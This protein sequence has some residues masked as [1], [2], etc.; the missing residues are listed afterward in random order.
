[1]LE[2]DMSDAAIRRVID[3]L[4][5]SADVKSLLYSFSKAMIKVGETIIKSWAEKSSTLSAYY[6]ENTLTQHSANI[7]RNRWAF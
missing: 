3:N 4:D 2:F 7:W 6:Y 5:V 1:M